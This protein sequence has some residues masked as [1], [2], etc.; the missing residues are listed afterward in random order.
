MRGWPRILL[1]ASMR[2]QVF[3]QCA[4]R[5]QI[6]DTDIYAYYRPV[7]QE[8]QQ[9]NF[10][11]SIIH[12]QPYKN[13]RPILSIT[14]FCHAFFFVGDHS[15]IQQQNLLMEIKGR[16]CSIKEL[17]L[18]VNLWLNGR[19]VPVDSN[20]KCNNHIHI[21][22][23]IYGKVIQLLRFLHAAACGAK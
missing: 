21:M 2:R 14:F 23:D 11:N 7:S 20:V 16:K 3:R 22:N 10:K 1:T 17:K 13:M 5:Q 12:R 9:R 19:R 18:N 8:I 6:P 15:N 4:R